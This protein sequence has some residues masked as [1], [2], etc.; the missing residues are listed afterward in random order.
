MREAASPNITLTAA[1]ARRDYP[2]G[3][4]LEVPDTYAETLLNDRHNVAI[5]ASNA[6][7]YWAANLPVIPLI[8]GE[9][10]PAIKGW[11]RFADSMPTEEEKQ[12]WLE[13]FPDGNM[14][15][16]LG[17]ALGLFA[18]DIDSDDP[19]VIA[20]IK[21]V[22]P[23]TPWERVGKKGVVLLYRFNGNAT[24]HIRDENN[25]G[26]VDILSKG[27][28]VVLPPSIHPETGK[29]YWSNVELLDV[30]RMIP[31]GPPAVD[32]MVHGALDD[33]GIATKKPGP[34]ALTTFVPAGYRDNAMV[35]AAGIHALEILRGR[36]TLREALDQMRVWVETYPEKV[37]GDPVSVE[38]A[39]KKLIEFLVR[40][41]ND[42]KKR[43]PV[44]WDE[45]LTPEDKK[46]YGVDFGEEQ[47]DW[48]YQK[49]NTYLDELISTTADPRSTS[50]LEAANF[51]LAR[52]ASSNALKPLE[53]DRLLKT[54]GK[55]AQ[56]SM[57][58]L[59]QQVKDLQL[60][61]ADAIDGN[62]HT[63]I[64][65]RVLADLSKQGEIRFDG[66]KFWQWNGSFWQELADIKILQH[67][68]QEYGALPAAKRESDHRGIHKIMR[69]NADNPLKTADINGINFANGFLTPDLKLHEHNPDH[70]CTYMLSSR[71]L[72]DGWDRCPMWQQFLYEL[73]GKNEDYEQ[74]KLALQE[75]MAAT[76]FGMAP[77]YQRAFCIIGPEETGKSTLRQVP[78]GLMPADVKCAINP[79][80]WHDKFLP[81]QMFG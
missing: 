36:I 65:N 11:Q 77:K 66:G 43:L 47:V 5:F 7:K 78:E 60:V 29:P 42:K 25:K 62:D 12:Q 38:K 72:E 69:T 4:G 13:T 32:S 71:Y 52:I 14:G 35:A 70:G 45:G 3:S 61:D 26:L 6:P 48:N 51:L 27:T 81:A 16:P 31:M 68:N 44:G 30:L 15:L 80:D 46:A 54:L 33:I 59:K 53:S 50:F 57:K 17:P 18:V 73:W 2:I 19:K 55:V 75:A 74:Q 67:I 40:D 10:R 1:L 41:I 63:E 76:L 39:Q 23:T 21:R 64:A 24:A 58:T 9:K 22:L 37:I 49:L 34:N 8:S 28:Q 20:A 56:V 79:M